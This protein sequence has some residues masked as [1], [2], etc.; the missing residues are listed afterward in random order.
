MVYKFRTDAK[1]QLS[2]IEDIDDGNIDITIYFKGSRYIGTF[3]TLKNIDSIMKRHS[4]SG[5][6]ASGTYFCA[7]DMI[8]VRSLN[9]DTI[10]QAV[11]HLIDSGDYEWVLEGP[12]P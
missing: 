11:E 3:F 5:E 4:L 9:V 12:L 1:N 10:N 8:I 7:K 6:S 2:G